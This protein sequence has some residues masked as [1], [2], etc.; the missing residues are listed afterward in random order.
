MERKKILLAEDD[1][2][3]GSLLQNYLIVKGYNV[4]LYTDGKKALDGY[5]K[6]PFSICIVDV[7][8]PVMDGF[9]LVREI[10]KINPDSPVIYLT[11]RNQK[12]DIIEGFITG[13]DDYITKPFSMEELLY[14]IEAVLRRTSSPREEKS[15]ESYTIGEYHFD[16]IR[17]LLSI[18]DHTIKLTTK[19]SELLSLLCQHKNS[20]LERNYTLRT[21]WIDDNYFNARSMDVYITKLRKYLRKDPSIEIINVHGKGYKL[22]C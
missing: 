13:A 21:I 9:E 12:D 6:G 22:L 11:A 8:M 10:R 2:N 20:I 15:E 7:M 1:E 17:Q 18:N 14:R 16:T 5:K 19:E 4:D 3:L